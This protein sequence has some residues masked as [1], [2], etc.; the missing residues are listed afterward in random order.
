MGVCGSYFDVVC[1]PV[2]CRRSRCS[3]AIAASTTRRCDTYVLALPIAISSPLRPRVGR[4][5]KVA[6][7]ASIQGLTEISRVASVLAAAPSVVTMPPRKFDPAPALV[8]PSAA[9][10]KRL[11]SIG[12][13]LRDARKA[14]GLSQE[15]LA[16]R[17]GTVQRSITRWESGHCDPGFAAV[18]EIARICGVSLDWIAGV[19]PTRPI[20]LPGAVLLDRDVI[21]TIRDLAENGAKPE[22]IPEAMWRRPGID[23]VFV[24]PKR[25][26]VLPMAEAEKLDLDVRQWLR[27]ISKESK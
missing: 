24:M 14:A 8:S 6:P 17:L 15:E 2:V 18:S 13:R 23:Y 7:W 16:H 25:L 1:G 22:D 3:R 11:L 10:A 19:I 20:L 26:E 12:D 21:D 9:L 27:T 5:F 4:L